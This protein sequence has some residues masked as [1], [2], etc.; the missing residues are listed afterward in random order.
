MIGTVRI[1]DNSR[2]R[3]FCFIRGADGLDY[4]THR[5]ELRGGLNIDTVLR[6]QRVVFV[7]T[8]GVKGLKANEVFPITGNEA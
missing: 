5:N 1:D 2:S 3:G 6:D 7:P 4:F 8:T